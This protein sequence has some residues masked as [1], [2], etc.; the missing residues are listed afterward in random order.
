MKTCIARVCLLVMA[1][2]LLAACGKSQEPPE[3]LEELTAQLDTMLPDRLQAY[4]APGA[5]VALVEDGEVAWVQGYGLADRDAGTP[6]TEATV[7]QVASLSK[8]VTAWGVMRLVEKGQ[9]DLDAPVES[10]LTRWHLPPSRFDHSGVTVRRL[11]SHTAG[12]APWSFAGTPVEDTPPTLIDLLSG[13]GAAEPVR[14]VRQPGEREVYSNSGYLILQLLIEEVTGEPFAEYMQR[15]VL[16]PLDMQSSAYQWL[17]ELRS[18]TA[19]GY[20]GSPQPVQHMSYPQ[21]AGG[22]YS[23]AADMAAW[24]AAAMPGPNGEPAGRDVLQPQ[25]VG[26]MQTPVLAP[27]AGGNGLG[28]VIEILPQ[29][30]RLVLHVGDVPGWKAQYTALPDQRRGI[31]VLTNSTAGRY[32]I[33]DATCSWIEWTAQDLPRTCRIYRGLYIAIPAVAGLIGLAAGVSAGQLAMRIRSGRRKLVWPPPAGTPRRDMILSLAAIAFWWLFFAPRIGPLMPP[34]F[35]LV[36]LAYTLW[37][38]VAAARGLTVWEKQE[39][40]ETES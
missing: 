39:M 38:L 12:I 4:R 1:V 18:N 6:V 30:Q 10:Y 14:V 2:L 35:Q 27:E 16:I 40:N 29:G 22:L 11:L 20:K 5:A 3:T 21:A 28:Y 32:V 33:A 23:T 17:P 34:T 31:V 36:S 37:F 19:A 24:L 8:S 26:M 7:F 9:V 13:T 25:T 15:Q